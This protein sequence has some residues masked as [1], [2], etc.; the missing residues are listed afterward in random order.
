MR[1]FD[2]SLK[3]FRE[4]DQSVNRQSIGDKNNHQLHLSSLPNSRCCR[5]RWGC[6]RSQHS[7]CT[8]LLLCRVLFFSASARCSFIHDQGS[9]SV[10]RDQPA[11]ELLPYLFLDL[12]VKLSLL[13]Q[14]QD[15]L[16]SLFSDAF[17][18]YWAGQCINKT[19]VTN[20]HGHIK[21][22]PPYIST[23]SII[24]QQQSG[25]IC[26]WPTSW[27]QCWPASQ[28]QGGPAVGQ[29]SYQGEVVMVHSAHI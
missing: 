20:K 7:R 16:L 9:V 25:V 2:N 15:R 29:S 27:Q 23:V 24:Q 11:V 3:I 12:T 13:M 26:R 6:S 5:C 28:L 14:M 21:D 4:N 10:R 18:N 8:S 22:T 17:F 19:V 1:I